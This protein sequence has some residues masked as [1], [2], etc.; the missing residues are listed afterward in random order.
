MASSTARSPGGSL[1]PL[2]H[3]PPRA[4]TF[5]DFTSPPP[6]AGSGRRRRPSVMTADSTDGGRS[7]R[8]ATSMDDLLVPGPS[9]APGV[10]PRPEEPSLWHSTPLALA[11]LPPLGGLLFHNG[12]H[13]MTDVSLL[14]LM[15]I[16]LNWSVRL[17]W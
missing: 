8:S 12:G 13:I 14:A 5:A 15:S 10:R 3:R 2:R 16:F 6:T 11:L 4:A 7:L 17:P 9:S 1:S